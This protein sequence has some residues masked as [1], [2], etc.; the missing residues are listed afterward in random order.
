[1][2]TQSRRQP[3]RHEDLLPPHGA[4]GLRV[5]GAITMTIIVIRIVRPNIE[6][7]L[8]YCTT[9]NTF[10]RKQTFLNSEYTQHNHCALGLRVPGA[11]R[12]TRPDGPVHGAL[13]EH[14]LQQGP[15]D[16]NSFQ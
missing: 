16:Y 1:M 3:G 7:T 13:Q 12:Q 5:P 9:S 11:R 4:L 6:R 8:Q 10:T 14:P 15:R 2:Y